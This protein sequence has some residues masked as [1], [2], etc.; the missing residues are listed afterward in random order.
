M[1]FTGDTHKIE[2]QFLTRGQNAIT[3]RTNKYCKSNF[4]IMLGPGIKPGTHF[5]EA[6]V[7]LSSHMASIRQNRV[8][9]V[10]HK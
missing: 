10:R 7:P 4:I 8:Q 9:F 5:L 1:I 3:Q 6:R 2:L